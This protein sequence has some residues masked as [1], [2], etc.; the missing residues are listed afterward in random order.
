M[1]I[2][3]TQQ[4]VQTQAKTLKLYLKVCDQF[5]AT[6][7][8]QDDSEIFHQDDGYVPE[9]MPGDHYGDY[10]ILDIDL[11]TGKI[12]NWTAPTAEQLQTWI[13]SSEED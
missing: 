8:D 11:D 10:V 4:P 9:F 12:L 2:I 3:T 7:T 13:A 6:M 5:T 1:P